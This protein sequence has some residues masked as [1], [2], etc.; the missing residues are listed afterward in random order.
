MEVSQV[1]IGDLP[2]KKTTSTLPP[3]LA[4]MQ[5][6]AL[7]ALAPQPLKLQAPSTP[8]SARAGTRGQ[9]CPGAF[10]APSLVRMAAVAVMAACSGCSAVAGE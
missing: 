3:Y 9:S 2:R 10:Q 4:L 7:P 6:M 8:A 5:S 1:T